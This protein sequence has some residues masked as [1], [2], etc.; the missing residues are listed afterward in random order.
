MSGG[1]Y[2]SRFLFIVRWTSWKR[3]GGGGGDD[4]VCVTRNASY[5][6]GLST[7]GCSVSNATSR[8][9]F[10]LTIAENTLSQDTLSPRVMACASCLSPLLADDF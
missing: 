10:V 7:S 5:F 6:R 3:N 1:I 9:F 2:I 8:L 4:D